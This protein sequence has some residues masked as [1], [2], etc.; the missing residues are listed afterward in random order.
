M[1]ICVFEDD[2]VNKMAPL[3]YL[4]H[5]SELICGSS[6]LLDKL[7]SR[8]PKKLQLDLHTRN[9]LTDLLTEKNPKILI[10]K[11]KKDDYLLLNSRVIFPEKFLKDLFSKL[12]LLSNT[13]L[14]ID[15]CVIAAIIPKNNVEGL[16]KLISNNFIL[17]EHL[18]GINLRRIDIEQLKIKSSADIKIL[19]YPTDILQHFADEIENDFN[20]VHKIVKQRKNFKGVDLINPGDIS[21][22]SSAKILPCVVLDASYGKIIVSD[23][24]V[25]EPFTYI[26]G[27]VCIGKH[28]TVRSVT[29]LYGPVN[30]GEYCKVGGELTHSILHSY[31]NKQHLGFAGHSYICEWVNLGAGTTTS[32][33]KNNYS[34]IRIK[35]GTNDVATESIFIGSIIGDHTKTGINSM[36]NT[37]SIIGVSCNL[38]GGGYQDKFIRSFSWAQSGQTDKEIYKLPK[39]LSTA[40]ISMQRRGIKMTDYYEKVFS[41]LFNNLNILPV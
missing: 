3:N 27:P 8:L 31:V 29:K 9:Y 12:K 30:I 6:S 32:N 24:V 13:F 41:Y 37:G 25:I 21:I 39:A 40:K 16:L 34:R 7:K 33:L 23:N 17:S 19:K 4:R 22:S 14:T 10:N 1:R 38:F 11:I 20:G 5:T 36:L 26:Q 15:D 18:S 28:S 2:A 35:H